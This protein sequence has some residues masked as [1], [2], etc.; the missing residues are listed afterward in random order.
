MIYSTYF[1][2]RTRTGE[3]KRLAESNSVRP[4]MLS[5]EVARL[6]E[7]VRSNTPEGV[8]MRADFSDI[9]FAVDNQVRYH[10][11]FPDPAIALRQANEARLASARRQLK[12]AEDTVRESTGAADR[13][14]IA[15]AD[16]DNASRKLAQLEDELQL[17]HA[18]DVA[19]AAKTA[20]VQRAQQAEQAEAE[21]LAAEKAAA[22]K[23]AQDKAAAEQAAQDRANADTALAL[24]VAAGKAAA[25][26]EKADKELAAAANPAPTPEPPADQPP[27]Q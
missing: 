26:K 7:V 11:E 4:G 1:Q 10:H 25:A 19:A 9:V 2:V 12:A 14:R 16:R 13:L 21:R 15:Q 3:Y 17:P 8:Q 18:S 5:A 20:A 24:N 27:A 6:Y 22:E 23:A